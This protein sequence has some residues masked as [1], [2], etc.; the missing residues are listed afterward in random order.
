[1]ATTTY[2]FEDVSCSLVHDSVGSVSTTGAGIGSITTT[3]S[4]DRT[5]H[6]V[7]ADGSVM[8]SKV[9]GK[10]G[11]I[12]LVVQQTSDLHKWLIKWYNYVD[13]ADSSEWAGMNITIK[14]K[15]LG[16]STVCTGVSPHGIL[17]L[18]K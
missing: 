7:A 13:L 18:L 14:S 16:D 2:S 11:A 8:V 10:N 5:V 12:A 3:M 17:W 15:N 1:M 4:T 6:D 9:A